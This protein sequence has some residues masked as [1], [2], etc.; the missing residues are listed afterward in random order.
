MARKRRGRAIHGW[1]AIDK[2]AGVTSTDVVNRVRRG[3]NAAKVGH[4]GTLDPIA[5]GILPIALGEATKTVAYV[6]DGT[7]AYDFTIRLGQATNTDDTEGTVT[8]ESDLRPDDAAILAALPAFVGEIE[9]V[10]PAYS[11]IKVDGQRA[12]DL[13]RQDTPAELQARPVWI[14]TLDL[15]DRPDRDHARLAMTCG[16]GAYVRAVARDLGR[17]L[18]CHAHVTALRRTR[19]GPFNEANAITLEKLDGVGQD[20]DDS[21][22]LLLPVQTALDGIPALSLTEQEAHRLSIGQPVS[23][24]RIAAREP[25]A[26]RPAGATVRAMAGDRLVALARIDGGEVRPVRVINL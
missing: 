25:L 26:F 15:I 3:L 12:Y 14:A 22:S 24:L 13:A 16:K 10:P 9:Q 18:G 4:G 2:P 6:M 23:L 19:C 21:S 20:P 7:K 8:A 11:A 1:L 5:T 17:A